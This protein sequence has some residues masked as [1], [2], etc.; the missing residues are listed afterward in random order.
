MNDGFSVRAALDGVL[1]SL[2][3]ALAAFIPRALTALGIVVLG[4]IVAGIARRVVRTAFAR[5]KIDAL[6]ERVGVTAMLARLGVAD[7]PGRVLGRLVY[8]LLVLL[9]LQSG[10][11]AV[12]LVAVADSITS[13]FG[14]LP[15]LAA[16]LIV[17]VVALLLGQFAGGAVTR[18]A[19]DAGVEFAPVLGRIV[20][21]LVVFMGALM[22]VTQ[23]RIETD[24][25][26]SVVL[27]LLAGLSLALALTFGL[28]T[29]DVT[30][31][32]VAGFYAR[33]LFRPGERIEIAGRTAILAGIAPVH[34]VLDEDGALVTVPNAVFLEQ[35]V[36]Q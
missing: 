22:A 18:A 3:G 34:A 29:R 33:K 32:L 35:A 4:L 12:G 2:S 36:R 9:F 6:L 19:R 14:Y 24:V 23:L 16:A 28:G 5:L 1:H 27:V 13:L 26:R 21:A 8:Y 20:S 7:P 11:Q 30:R 25:I 17:L 10:A 15:S 31:N